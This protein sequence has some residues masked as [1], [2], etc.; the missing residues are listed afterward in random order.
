[1]KKIIVP[2]DFSPAALNAVNYA[3]D[4]ALAI[5]A[6]VHLL[7]IYQI[8]ISVSETPLVFVSVEELKDNAE[9]KL[10]QMKK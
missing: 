8:P 1:M 3:A 9:K 10:A 7:H 6:R 2:T 4:M 5:N